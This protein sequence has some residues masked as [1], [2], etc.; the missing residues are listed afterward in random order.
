MASINSNDIEKKIDTI[1]NNSNVYNFGV[2]TKIND[3]VII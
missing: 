1:L 2:V 3:F